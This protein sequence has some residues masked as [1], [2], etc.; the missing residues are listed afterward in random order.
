MQIDLYLPLSSKLNSKWIKDLNIKPD[1]MN[2]IKKNAW[3]SPE[4]TVIGDNFLNRMP[5]IQVLRSSINK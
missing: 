2:L 1:T 3:N 5:M 4:L